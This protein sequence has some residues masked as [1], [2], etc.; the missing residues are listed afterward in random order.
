MWKQLFLPSFPVTS[1]HCLAAI[2]QSE[3]RS[4]F[5]KTPVVVQLSLHIKQR[6]FN[7]VYSDCNFGEGKS[8][9]YDRMTC[10][11]LESKLQHEQCIRNTIRVGPFESVW[12]WNVC[13]NCFIE[14]NLTQL[15]KCFLWSGWALLMIRPSQW[16]RQRSLLTDHLLAAFKPSIPLKAPLR[17][18]NICLPAVSQSDCN[19]PETSTSCNGSKTCKTRIHVWKKSLMIHMCNVNSTKMYK[20]DCLLVA[21][22]TPPV[23]G[24][25]EEIASKCYSDGG[26]RDTVKAQRHEMLFMCCYSIMQGITTE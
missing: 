18:R 26:D 10:T 5:A 9:I 15:F 14:G 23:C 3:S 24:G 1:K 11:Y 2:W 7:A 19:R 25:Q 4:C 8:V 21:A 22:I 12:V 20:L 6:T 13:N 17:T 16:S